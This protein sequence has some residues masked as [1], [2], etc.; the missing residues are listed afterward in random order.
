MKFQSFIQISAVA[1]LLALLP[2]CWSSQPQKKSGLVLV[3]VLDKEFY[4]DCRIK[5]SV[6]IPF[7][8]IENAADTIDKDADVVIYCSNYQC[9]SSEYA[10]RKLQEQG[11][12]H[13]SVYE[14]GMA[15]WYQEGLPVEGPQKQAYLKKSCPQ[16]PADEHSSVT[17]ISMDDLAHKMGIQRSNN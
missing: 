2:G 1:L 8:M 11:F 10:A 7:E 16:L 9:T 13:V 4:D 5:G 3:N 14:G 6:H 17:V 15:E 12:K